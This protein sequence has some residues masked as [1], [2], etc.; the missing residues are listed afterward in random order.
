MPRFLLRLI[1]TEFKGDY[2]H[3]S[4]LE[5]NN[6]SALDHGGLEGAALFTE[7]EVDEVLL[8]DAANVEALEP[9]P[10]HEPDSIDKFFRRLAADREDFSTLAALLSGGKFLCSLDFALRVKWF[11]DDDPSPPNDE[12]FQEAIKRARDGGY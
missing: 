10:A 3:R 7:E 8:H 11:M 4:I 6:L 5:P 2:L 12:D 1:G 9:H